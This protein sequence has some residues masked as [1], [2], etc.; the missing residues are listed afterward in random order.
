MRENVCSPCQK[1][2]TV[3]RARCVREDKTAGDTWTARE[4]TEKRIVGKTVA[5]C[6]VGVSQWAI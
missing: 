6:R 2:L 3:K 1:T 4:F 5:S